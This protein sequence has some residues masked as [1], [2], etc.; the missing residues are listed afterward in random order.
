MW[1]NLQEAVDLVTFTEEIL[2]G[3]FNFLWSV[4]RHVAPFFEK[5]SYFTVSPQ[6][7]LIPMLSTN[8]N[9]SK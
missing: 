9:L 8:T 1:P 5:V 4:N 7:L 2:N 3:K 6:L